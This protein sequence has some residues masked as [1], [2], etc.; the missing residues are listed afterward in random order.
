VIAAAGMDVRLPTGDAQNLLGTGNTRTKIYAAVSSHLPK[1]SP[2]VNIG[3]TFKSGNA[4]AQDAVFVFGSEL[5]YAAGAEYVVNPRVTVV[6]DFVG[7]SLADEGRLRH[8]AT[9]VQLADAFVTTNGTTTIV[10]AETRSYTE[11]VFDQGVRLNTSF[12]SVGVKFNPSSTVIV[13]AHVLF[14]MTNTGLKSRPTPVIGV[15]YTLPIA[16]SR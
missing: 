14:P 12:T 4:D 9:S 2:H 8:R 10:P 1:V 3:Y 15:D 16:R 5:S 6:G 13:S 11:A 7:R